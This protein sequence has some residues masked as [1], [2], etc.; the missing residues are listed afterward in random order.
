[1]NPSSQKEATLTMND[2]D[3]DRGKSPDS[4]VL[5]QLDLM[6]A[7]SYF[8]KLFMPNASSVQI[9]EDQSTA[10]SPSAAT[11]TSQRPLENTTEFTQSATEQKLVWA[12]ILSHEIASLRCRAPL[13]KIRQV[14]AD[15]SKAEEVD[16]TLLEN[17]LGWAH[18]PQAREAI[19]CACLVY[20][21]ARKVLDHK[22][23]DD[24]PTLRHLTSAGLHDV[25]LTFWIYAGTHSHHALSSSQGGKESSENPLLLRRPKS[26]GGHLMVCREN[27]YQILMELALLCKKANGNVSSPSSRSIWLMAVNPF[28]ELLYLRDSGR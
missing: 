12:S 23:D 26:E 6:I 13:G 7:Q 16:E 15:N 19:T 17:L 4:M 2:E 8:E 21:F 10:Q 20:T 18:E 22:A 14:P 1:M 25:A 5:L 24:S 28:A 9:F 11:A 27:A 3:R